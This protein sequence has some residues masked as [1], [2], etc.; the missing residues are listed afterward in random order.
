M[1]PIG[2]LVET[3]VCG[4]VDLP[5]AGRYRRPVR[6]GGWV[7]HGLGHAVDQ[8]VRGGVLEAFG[9]LVHVV[10]AEA[11]V[12]DQVGLD[13][14]VTPQHPQCFAVPQAGETHAAVGFV[15]QQPVFGESADHAAD[16][17]GLHLQNLGELAGSGGLASFIQGVDRLQVVFNRA[18]QADG[19][20]DRKIM[21]IRNKIR[22]NRVCSG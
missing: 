17:G 19:L 9:L 18:G 5:L 11:E 3:R 14:A 1:C 8:F 13:D 15:L 21:E 20:H 10:P 12:P 22:D 2:H 16:R 4:R 6:V 7:A